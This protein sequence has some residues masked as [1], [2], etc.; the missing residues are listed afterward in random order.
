MAVEF[1]DKVAIVTGGASG[2][3]EAVVRRL[4]TQGAKVVVADADGDAA[5][6]V[7]SRLKDA[8]AVELDV[9]RAEAVRALVDKTLD[10]FGG[11]HLAVNTAGIAGLSLPTAEYPLE[12]WHRLIDINQHGV[13][14]GLRYEI[15]AMLD[16][17]GGAIVNVAPILG[18]AGR[19][20][21][22]ARVAAKHAVIGM[23]RTAALEY[24]A[25]GIRINAVGPRLMGAASLQGLDGVVHDG[26]AALDTAPRPG[27]R[28]N[29]AALVCFLLSDEASA[30]TGSHHLVDAGHAA[31]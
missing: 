4:S 22:I 10:A 26:L 12:E 24:A 25:R 29:V 18:N 30:L 14:Y 20:H 19:R 28:G 17:G 7:A 31:G 2:I 1:S 8:L 27:P 6:R 23:T 11:L 5:C 16:S 9:S 13:M 15:P 3:G 21:S